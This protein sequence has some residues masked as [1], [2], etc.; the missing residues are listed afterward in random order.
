MARTDSTGTL[1]PGQ[2]LGLL[3]CICSHG[4][5]VDG[6]AASQ[7]LPGLQAR[8]DRLVY[9]RGGLSLPV[10]KPH[11]FVYFITIENR[12]DRTVTLHGRKW[13]LEQADG[14]RQVIEGDK[15]VGETPRIA[16]GESF[17][18]NSYHV[19]GSNC[20]VIGSF[21][22]TDDTGARIHVVVS[23]FVMVIPESD[24]AE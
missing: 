7:L 2:N 6:L 9:H 5:S 4:H 22:G 24:C 11:A 14:E 3:G 18:Y 19:T 15:I 13:V 12:S 20:R 21:H 16:P 23:A 17:S 1:S 8:L 10:G